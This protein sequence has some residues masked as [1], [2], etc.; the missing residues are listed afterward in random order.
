M[1]LNLVVTLYEYWYWT[2]RITW[3]NSK[4]INYMLSLVDQVFLPLM[5]HAVNVEEQL[6]ISVPDVIERWKGVAQCRSWV[7]SVLKNMSSGSR[8]LF[9][10]ENSDGGWHLARL[11]ATGFKSSP[12]DTNYGPASHFMMAYGKYG[13]GESTSTGL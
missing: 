8:A 6:T 12:A 10:Y 5:A 7:L 1:E 9:L 3:I 13:V 2:L 11:G 4:L